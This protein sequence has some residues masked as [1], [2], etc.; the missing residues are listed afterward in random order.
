LRQVVGRREERDGDSEHHRDDEAA[1]ENGGDLPGKGRSGEATK[2][3]KRGR[4][5]N[6]ALFVI[7]ASSAV[8][9]VPVA[10]VAGF[11]RKQARYHPHQHSPGA[12]PPQ[13]QQQPW[14]QCGRWRQGTKLV[15]AGS[16][17]SL[18]E[19]CVVGVACHF[20]RTTAFAKTPACGAWTHTHSLPRSPSLLLFSF[21]WLATLN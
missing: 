7:V 6:V 16:G 14:A 21:E 13:S 18:F 17:G 11:M 20:P 5:I 2:T 4:G 15:V 8:L 3:G 10:R 9:L 1:E 12:Q 19:L